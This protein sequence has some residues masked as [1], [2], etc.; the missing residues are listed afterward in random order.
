MLELIIGNKSSFVAIRVFGRE[1]T[2]AT[3]YDD[4]NWLTAEVEVQMDAFSGLAKGSLVVNE[5]ITFR[6]ELAK[7]YN[8]LNGTAVF[9]TLEE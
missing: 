8:A 9:S 3:N 7:L 2:N 5:F 1:H 6:E 4:A